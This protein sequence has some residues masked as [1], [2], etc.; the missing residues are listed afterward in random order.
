M[1]AASVLL[2]WVSNRALG[3]AS[4]PR[5]GGESSERMQP[6]QLAE[7][8]RDGN[9]RR[10]ILFFGSSQFALGLAAPFYSVYMLQHL[11]LSYT[12]ISLF[13]AVNMI[14][15]ISGYR[16]WAG[17]ID[18]FGGKPVLQLLLGPF[19]AVPLLWVFADVDSYW[20]IPVALTIGG[21]LGAG[22]STGITPLMFDLLPQGPKKPVYLAVWS[23]SVSLI[24]GLGPL[25]GSFMSRSLAGV[26]LQLP[27]ATVPA[28]CTSSSPPAPPRASLPLLLL[29]Q[30]ER[31]LRD[32]LPIAAEADVDREP[33][34]LLFRQR[35]LPHVGQREPPRPGRPG[36][37]QVAQSA[38]GGAAGAGDARR[39]PGGAPGGGLRPRGERLPRRRRSISSAN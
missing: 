19:A 25:L 34:A 33:A 12:T 13:S 5:H 16:I 18:R 37:R 35:R 9:F 32:Q 7:P 17:L 21:F 30:G 6:R 15:S 23:A 10:A 22:V 8:L 26:E 31:P 11:G 3:A 36:T 1:F 2:G 38:R 27:G 28:R 14:A 20:L 24:Y 29:V 4:Y 39:Q